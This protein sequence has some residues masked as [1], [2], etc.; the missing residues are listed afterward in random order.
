MMLD[1][2]F[3]DASITF[4]HHRNAGRAR[5]KRPKDARTGTGRDSFKS[6]PA[7]YP[8]KKEELGKLREL[9]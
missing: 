8:R 5:G 7:G 6:F 2:S 9:R 3:L 4:Q 1:W